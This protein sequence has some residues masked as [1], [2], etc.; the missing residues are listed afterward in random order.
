M[1]LL[2]LVWL[3]LFALAI[4]GQPES[5]LDRVDP[6][7]WWVG[8]ENPDLQLL[9]YGED[10]ALTR[11]VI[12]YPGVTLTRV[13]T[14]E[15]PNYLFLYLH[16][17]PN[18]APGTFTLT[19]KK[20][21][22]IYATHDYTLHKRPTST[23]RAQGLT[24]GDV[25]YLL[26]PD[27][28]A[29][30]D[31]ANDEVQGMLEGVNR[32]VPNDRH[33]GDLAGIQQHLDYFTDLGV[34]TLWLNPVLENNM[35]LESYHGYAITD[36]YRIDPRLGTNQAYRDFVQAAHD[37]GLKVM[38]DQVFNHM[39]TNNYLIRDLPGSDWINQW[40]A[41]TRSNF[42]GITL[43]DPHATE[44]DRRRMTHGWFDSTMADLNQSQPQLQQYLIQASIFWIE[45]AG[46]DG[47]RM[48]TYPY[49]DKDAMAAWVKAVKQE[50]PDFYL[51]AETWL[52]GVPS[53]SYWQGNEEKF[54]GYNPFIR[55]ISDF[56]MYYAFMDAFR[57]GGNVYKVYETLARDF[58]YHEA[59]IYN[60][61][62][63]SNHD[64]DRLFTALGEDFER[65]KMAWTCLLTM[66]GIPQLYYG[67][68]VLLKGKH[69]H[70][71][72]IARKDMPGG[73]PGDTATVFTPEG[74]TAQQNEAYNYLKKLLHWRQGSEAI[75]N[76]KLIH[77]KPNGNIYVYARYTEKDRVVVIINNENQPVQINPATYAEVFDGATQGFD[78]I[79]EKTLDLSSGISVPA[80]HAMVL[81]VMGR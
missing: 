55:S 25:M 43:T 6:T 9:V 4:Y 41:Y 33:G 46:I 16:I 40:P 44:Y 20:G 49:N 79:R 72:G 37:Q 57:D 53:E 78:V 63:A 22:K 18:T 81:E 7:F 75:A 35:P 77:Y 58:L 24:P 17:G 5:R 3:S 34:T 56:P 23:G 29:N 66:R 45:Y 8:M 27:R 39:G 42:T 80:H 62:F 52:P 2:L 38:M 47:I 64:V 71:H 10:I 68:E 36:W 76:G 26:M 48:D 32:A 60:K 69:V 12:E 51:V 50:Y 65:V 59:P 28:F 14:L 61:I 21:R 1:R 15:N 31:P 73:W 70:P 11:P 13:V 74:R 30:G 54:D 67:T 19:F